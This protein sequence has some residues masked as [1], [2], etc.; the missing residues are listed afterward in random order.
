MLIYIQYVIQKNPECESQTERSF[1]QTPKE[2]GR[3][4]IFAL[5]SQRRC[6]ITSLCKRFPGSNPN[7]ADAPDWFRTQR[8]QCI[9]RFLLMKSSVVGQIR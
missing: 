5:L 8:L 4:I 3:K 9:F 6:Y 2:S 7:F 1:A